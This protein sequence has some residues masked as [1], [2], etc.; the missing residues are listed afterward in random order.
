MIREIKTF[1]I[2]CNQCHATETFTGLYGPND[3]PKDWGIRE[4]GPCG[5]TNYFRKEDLCPKCMKKEKKAPK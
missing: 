4:V 3:K 5:L 1:E 2:V